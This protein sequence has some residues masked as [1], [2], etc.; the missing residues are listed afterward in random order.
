MLNVKAREN[1]GKYESKNS[2]GNYQEKLSKYREEK[3]LL[4]LAPN[5]HLLHRVTD[6]CTFTV[7]NPT[8]YKFDP[9]CQR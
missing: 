8:E 7:S 1:Q 4:T 9:P 5:Y 6:I 2:Q 3:E